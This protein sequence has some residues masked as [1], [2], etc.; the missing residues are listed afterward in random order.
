MNKIEELKE[1]A[2]DLKSILFDINVS[3]NNL[4]I[5]KHER[6]N[7][8]RVNYFDNY[9]ILIYHQH[10][11]LI[12]QLAKIFSTNDKTQKRNINKLFNELQK[13][14]FYDDVLSK[15]T[16]ETIKNREE[17]LIVLKDLKAKIKLNA[18]LIKS[19]IDNRNTSFAHTD[20]NDLY[21]K[22][23]LEE[24]HVLV[25]LSNE[26]YNTLFGKLLDDKFNPNF[27]NKYDLRFLLDISE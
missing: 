15:N 17:L 16:M 3:L 23:D 1:W 25:D 26:I 14:S 19:V 12:I 24:Y 27:G 21:K 13:D 6:F 18:N 2:D 9:L 5:L 22:I 20:P 11:I 4:R 10:F 8:F 7:K